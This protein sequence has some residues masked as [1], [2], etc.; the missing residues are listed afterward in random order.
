MTTLYGH[1]TELV[2]DDYTGLP[3]KPVKYRGKGVQSSVDWDQIQADY[4][5]RGG[6]VDATVWPAVGKV[7]V[8]TGNANSSRANLHTFVEATDDEY[9]EPAE[10]VRKPRGRQRDF[11]RKAHRPNSKLTDEQRAEIRRRRANGATLTVLADDYSVSVTTI[12]KTVK[13]GQP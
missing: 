13:A 8:I 1:K 11:T 10:R 5:A 3:T 9:D 12:V 6:Q 7:V 4:V 2:G